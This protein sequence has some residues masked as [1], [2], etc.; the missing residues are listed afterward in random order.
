AAANVEV[1]STA[2]KLD[3]TGGNLFATDAKVTDIKIVDTASGSTVA[4]PKDA[5]A[6]ATT[7][8]TYTFTE[9]YNLSAGQTRT[10]KVTADIANNV[11]SMTALKATLNAF[12]ATAVRNLDTST[13]LGTSDIVP[14]SAIAGNTHQIKTPSLTIGLA[15]TPV[16]QTYIQGVQGAQVAGVTIKAGDAGD[17]KVNS[18]QFQGRIDTNNASATCSVSPDGTFA[19]GRENAACSSVA[20]VVSTMKLW[21]GST[22]IGSTKSPSS[23]A[24]A[25]QGGLVTFDNLNLTV[26]KGQTITLTLSANL[27]SSISDL[28][29]A[30]DFQLANSGVTATDVDGNSITATGG[31]VDGAN[32]TI[33]AAGSVTVALAPDDSESEAGLLVGGASNAVLA[34][35]KFNATNEE[36]KLSKA[37]FVV[38]GPTA[39]TAVS[40][41]DG[42]TLVGGPSSVDGSGNA[43]F[44]SMNFVIPKDG[45]KV[46]TVKGNLNT[47]G[48][49][50]AASGTLATVTLDNFGSS[51]FEVRGTSAGSSTLLTTAGAADTAGRAKVLRRTKP[52]L[53]LVSLPTSTLSSGEQ[54]V[55][56]FTVS[57]DA[58]G[59]VAFRSLTL[60]GTISAAPGVAAIAGNSSVRRVGDSTNLAGTSSVAG[61]GC[62]ATTAGACTIS[63]SFANDEVVAAGTSRTYDVRETISGT[64]ISGDSVSFK[65]DGEPSIVVETNDLTGTAPSLEINGVARKFTWSDMSAAPHIDSVD[66]AND[67]GGD[68]A[69]TDWTNG[70][71]VK[72][73]PTDTQVLTK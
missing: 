27:A 19:N 21:S 36:L 7:T 59:D 1:R 42:S 34:K 60:P 49:S 30:I 17:V 2:I 32:M 4:G 52:T 16:T 40:L 31:T 20:D 55:M 43:D 6:T 73:L 54:V 24:T 13:Y 70:S 53:S 37:R 72:V 63:I 56:R 22:Q 58:A 33:A 65:I 62:T 47:V 25:G 66:V 29:D 71:Y 39:V 3:S 5:T 64:L 26:P 35:Y 50:G 41:Y 12:G 38:S 9:T 15:S 23:N 51:L 45:S 68:I 48:S 10:F 57:A 46:L 14:S 8:E 44:S 18:L 28:N 61:A 67:G 11:G 69:S